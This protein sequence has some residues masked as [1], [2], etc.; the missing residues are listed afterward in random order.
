MN[1]EYKDAFNHAM[2]YEVGGFWDPEDD[3]VINGRMNDKAQRKKS[4][5]IYSNGT[6]KVTRNFLVHKYPQP[7]P[8]CQIVIPQKPEKAKTAPTKKRENWAKYF[9]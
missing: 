6:T 3:D 9:I 7:E 1:E 4:F 2:I 5:I 8:G